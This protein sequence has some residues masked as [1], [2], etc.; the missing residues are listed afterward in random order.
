[1]RPVTAQGSG[2]GSGQDPRGSTQ[3]RAWS[4]ERSRSQGELTG[5]AMGASRDSLRGGA[6]AL[7]SLRRNC[8]T[9]ESS[10]RMSTVTAKLCQRES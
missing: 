5:L 1:M 7:R 4:R 10:T 6:L 8:A 3:S 2:Q 9:V